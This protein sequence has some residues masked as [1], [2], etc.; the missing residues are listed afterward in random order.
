M[1]AGAVEEVA[2]SSLGQYLPKIMLNKGRSRRGHTPA[3]LSSILLTSG[4]A[5]CPNTSGS[6]LT[7]H[8]GDVSLHKVRQGRRESVPK[9][10]G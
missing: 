9:T 3:S 6:P 10:Q 5:H 7:E 8:S 2:D 1:R 4:D